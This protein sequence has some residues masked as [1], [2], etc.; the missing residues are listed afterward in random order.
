MEMGVDSAT[1]IKADTKIGRSVKAVVLGE[2]YIERK[3]KC[4]QQ[5][6]VCVLGE[7]ERSC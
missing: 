6:F 5:T 2:A 4:E 1:I 7:K 3:T